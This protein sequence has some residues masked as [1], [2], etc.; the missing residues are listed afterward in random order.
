MKPLA[1]L[2]CL[3]AKL[4]TILF[5]RYRRWQAWPRGWGLTG[6]SLN[7]YHGVYWD[8]VG[9]WHSGPDT[10]KCH[11]NRFRKCGRHVSRAGRR[12]LQRRA[13]SAEP[14]T[15]P[16]V[17]INGGYA[18]GG[19]SNVTG[20]TPTPPPIITTSIVGGTSAAAD[21]AFASNGWFGGGRSVTTGSAAIWFSALKPTSKAQISRV[22][23][24]RQAPPPPRTASTGSVR[25]AVASGLRPWLGSALR[26]GRLCSWRRPGQ[27]DR[28]RNNPEA[29]CHRHGLCRWRRV[30]ICVHP[31]LVR[32]GRISIHQ[33]RQ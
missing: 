5:I 2:L 28:R 29:R 4:D 13:G 27:A 24:P 9:F 33:S 10:C 17:G 6:A 1:D 23:A 11:G 16:Y 14:W 31:V 30:G 3:L 19:D 8:E 7:D 18:W 22:R 26:H 21:P 15:G 25:C 12:Q 32:Q 20:F